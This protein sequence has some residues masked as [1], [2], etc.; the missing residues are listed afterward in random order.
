MAL[1]AEIRMIVCAIIVHN[2]QVRNK[3][4]GFKFVYAA[5]SDNF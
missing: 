5:E 1:F 3:T 4:F 2:Q